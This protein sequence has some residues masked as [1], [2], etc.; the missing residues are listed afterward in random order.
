MRAVTWRGVQRW[1]PPLPFHS[2][3]NANALWD[4]IPLEEV[5]QQLTETTMRNYAIEYGLIAALI[6]VAVVGFVS[7][8]N[9]I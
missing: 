7:A 3:R 2:D 8:F 4:G 1:L 6:A 5:L 9:L